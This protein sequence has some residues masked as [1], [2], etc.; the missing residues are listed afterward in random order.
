[1]SPSLLLDTEIIYR[2][3]GENEGRDGFVSSTIQMGEW[4]G[5]IS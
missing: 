4:S 5:N 2:L 3:G 1:M